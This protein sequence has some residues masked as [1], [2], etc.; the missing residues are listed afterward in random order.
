[1]STIES[2][3][4]AHMGFDPDH[5]RRVRSFYLPFVDQAGLVLEIACGRGEFL[6]LLAERGVPARGLDKDEGMVAAA[7]AAGLDVVL[8]DALGFLAEPSSAGQF[9]AIFCAHVLEHLHPD[10]V[11]QLLEGAKRAL[12]PNGVFVAV[13]PNPACY[14]VLSHDFWCD[15]THLR[16]Y[17]L[18]LVEFLCTRAGLSIQE[19]GANPIDHPG[20]PPGYEASLVLGGDD[21][22]ATVRHLVANLPGDLRGVGVVIKELA[23]RLAE[24]QVALRDLESAHRRLVRGM[25]EPN[26][27]YVVAR[28]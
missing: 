17:D 19:S 2:D 27:I 14:A 26:E 25:Y 4:Y 13:V 24:M 28:A 23:R 22:S 9:G 7:R 12:R 15:P 16:F 21:L 5:S 18:P 1:M 11:A 6:S 8:A 20:P 10:E 3:Y